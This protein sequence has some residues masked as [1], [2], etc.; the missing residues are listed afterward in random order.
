VR[1]GHDDASRYERL[2]PVEPLV[3]TRDDFAIVYV[4][5]LL[6]VGE[7]TRAYGILTEREFRPWEGGEGEALA[8]WDATLAALDLPMADPPSSLGEAR[9]PYTPP[10]ARHES[11]ETDYF[12]TS[13]PEL[14][15]FTRGID[16]D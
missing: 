14:L 11:G 2:R 5:L 9:S 7:A 3:M 16:D 10:A 4:R 8:A 12:A 6:T 13:L 1:L 15:L